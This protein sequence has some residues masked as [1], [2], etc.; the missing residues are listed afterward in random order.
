MQRSVAAQLP[1]VAQSL[2]QNPLMQVRPAP[3]S[4]L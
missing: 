2:W 1:S 4:R 3:Q